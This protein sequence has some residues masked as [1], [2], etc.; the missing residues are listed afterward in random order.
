MGYLLWKRGRSKKGLLNMA[1]VRKDTLVAPPEWW[2]HL[3]WH[4]RTVAK[5]ERQAAKKEIEK[6]RKEKDDE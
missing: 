1:H 5:A 6:D 4:K 3:R 2:D